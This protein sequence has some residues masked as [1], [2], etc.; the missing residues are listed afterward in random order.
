MRRLGGDPELDSTSSR[1]MLVRSR[2]EGLRS[3]ITQRGNQSDDAPV[4]SADGQLYKHNVCL[5]DY[6]KKKI[7]SLA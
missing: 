7:E 6:S 2:D 4:S 3:P 1:D 5:S